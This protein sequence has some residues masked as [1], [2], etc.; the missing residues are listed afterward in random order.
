MCHLLEAPRC[1]WILS[2]H[3]LGISAELKLF[4]HRR[5]DLV[6]YAKSPIKL[7]HVLRCSKKLDRAT[8]R[9]TAALEGGK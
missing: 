6:P 2:P 3:S 5:G 7:D 8:N 1:Q 9:L 4:G